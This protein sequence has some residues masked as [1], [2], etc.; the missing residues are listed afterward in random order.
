MRGRRTFSVRTRRL[1]RLAPVA[2]TAL[3]LAPAL[4]TLAGSRTAAP[5]GFQLGGDPGNGKAI[6]AR[7]CA[8]C[9][10]PAGDGRSKVADS[11][12]PR[13][14]DFTDG[15]LMSQR[16]DW[17]VYV[18]VRDGGKAAGLS[19]KMFAW[20]RLLTDQEIRDVSA[21]VRSLSR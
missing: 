4:V 9:H 8:V 2:I 3:V 10:G 13:P 5:P 12:S 19:P 18:A 7:S 21:Y 1:S 14:T 16:S 15:R 6:Y 17:E 20:N 11:M